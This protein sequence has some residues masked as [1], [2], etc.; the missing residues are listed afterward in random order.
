MNHLGQYQYSPRP[1]LVFTS[2]PPKTIDSKI[3]EKHTQKGAFICQLNKKKG[4]TFA[5]EVF[6]VSFFILYNFTSHS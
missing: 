6:I 5:A 2:A 3:F 1:D 4:F